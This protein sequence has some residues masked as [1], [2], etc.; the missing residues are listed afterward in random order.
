[1]FRIL[2]SGLI[3]VTS[4]SATEYYAKAEPVERYTIQSSVAGKVLF[5]DENIEGKRATKKEIILIDDE[6]DVKELSSV[7]K[8]IKIVEK[9]VELNQATAT[10]LQK[11]ADKKKINYQK[12][13]K[14]KTK[15][16]LDKDREYYDL[17]STQNTL[18]QSLQS[19]ESLKSQL[20]DLKYRY[21]SLKKSIKEKKVLYPDFTVYKLLVKSGQNV[22]PGTPL[23]EIADVSHARLV[24]FLHSEESKNV[25]KKVIY[26]DGKKTPYKVDK[27]YF[28]SDSQR[29]SSYKTE[30]IIDAPEI[31]SEL[32][33]V[34]FKNE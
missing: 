34:E 26:L 31:F 13:L 9:M 12:I 29:I 6:L 5:A 33:K 3:L 7:S 16:L 27:V 1:M 17:S 14:L 22:M 28:I 25:N 21:H 15:S 18:Y 2:F 24:L 32:V 10:N 19:I 4:L 20:E 23:L 8:K 11:I 30:I